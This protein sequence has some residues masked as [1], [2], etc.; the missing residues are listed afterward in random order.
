MRR[1]LLL[2]CLLPWLA[3]DAAQSRAATDSE[4]MNLFSHEYNEYV[5]RLNRG[6]VDVKQ[7]RRVVDA[8]RKIA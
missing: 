4:A 7:W 3:V 2:A 5:D 6:I 8:W 1:R